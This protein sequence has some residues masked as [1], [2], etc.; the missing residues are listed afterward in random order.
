MFGIGKKHNS[1]LYRAEVEKA[2]PASKDKIKL[3]SIAKII[4]LCKKEPAKWTSPE[5]IVADIMTYPG[6]V[7]S[8]NVAGIDIKAMVDEAWAL[9]DKEK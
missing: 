6:L 9:K 2:L 4:A 8:Y 3:E 7:K 5:V 1:N